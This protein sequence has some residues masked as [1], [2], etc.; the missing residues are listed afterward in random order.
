MIGIEQYT[1]KQLAIY[2]YAQ[3]IIRS[4]KIVKN[5]SLNHYAYFGHG[6]TIEGTIDLRKYKRNITV[7][8][9][10]DPLLLYEK[11]VFDHMAFLKK[12]S[13]I[14]EYYRYIAGY[15][16]LTHNAF[17]VYSSQ[18][19][20]NMIPN[21]LLTLLQKNIEFTGLINI[22]THKMIS[23]QIRI[24]K[25][26][27]LIDVLSKYDS[28]DIFLIVFTCRSPLTKEQINYLQEGSLSEVAKYIKSYG[29]KEVEIGSVQPSLSFNDFQ[30]KEDIEN[31]KR[32]VQEIED[33]I[34]TKQKKEME[35][36][37]VKPLQMKIGSY[38]WL[39]KMKRA[40]KTQAEIDGLIVEENTKM[41]GNSIEN[42]VVRML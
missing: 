18:S 42:L 21:M 35:T 33:E 6:W 28:E 24:S 13:S 27:D 39:M 36:L 5:A 1:E 12:S 10:Q 14:E 30:T 17:G 19:D 20:Y 37:V 38:S 9:L 29:I 31:V 40:G 11:S 3:S 25:L 2:K 15:A 4:E 41:A 16:E 22:A 23:P 32:R 8:A 34:I 7:I 26:S